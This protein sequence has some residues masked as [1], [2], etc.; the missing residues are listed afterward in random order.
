MLVYGFVSRP[1]APGRRK[2]WRVLPGYDFRHA[3]LRFLKGPLVADDTPLVPAAL[4]LVQAMVGSASAPLL[5]LDRRLRVVALSLTF[6]RAFDVDCDAA[7]GLSIF[8]LG[9][10]EWDSPRLRSLL[11]AT[12]DSGV[13]VASYEFDLQTAR[14]GM[15]RLVLHANKLA[16]DDRDGVR[17]LLAVA[18]VTDERVRDRQREA[19]VTDNEVL[20]RELQHRVANSLQIVA[21]VL[22][23]G[24]RKAST[25]ETRIH[26]TDAH[27]RVMSVAAV[28]KQLSVSG[29]GT[30]AL[31]AYL[32]RLCAS[33]GASMIHDHVQL[34]LTVTVDDSE[35]QAEV[36]VSLGLIVTELV[37]NALKHAFPGD[38]KG[39]IA[40]RYEATGDDWALTITDDGVG[41]N[42]GETT[43]P[44][45]GTAI[46]QALAKQLRA[47]IVVSDTGPGTQ[48]VIRHNEAATLK[49][50]RPVLVAV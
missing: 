29:T 47:E 27:H 2:I 19:L 1:S 38:R 12:V 30:V 44:G 31:K 10:G 20:M 45:L 18:D 7:V 21:S 8:V 25:D 28:Q 14:H 42:G 39:A 32:T 50:G 34:R 16:Y 22:M 36:S 46:V 24:A 41:M 9:D 13:E 40:V 49:R 33:I 26:L 37:I 48:V 17:L 11:A 23:Q 43:E 5:L 4:T 15:R 3:S 35:V 6:C